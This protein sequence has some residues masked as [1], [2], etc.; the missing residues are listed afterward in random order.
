ME[1]P[2]LQQ[3]LRDVI[4]AV[5]LLRHTFMQQFFGMPGYAGRALAVAIGEHVDEIEHLVPVPP[6]QI[7]RVGLLQTSWVICPDIA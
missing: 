6:V 5:E 4:M 3:P 2:V 7:R 1:L